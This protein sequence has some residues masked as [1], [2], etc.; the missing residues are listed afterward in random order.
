MELSKNQMLDLYKNMQRIRK[1]EEQACESFETGDVQGFLHVSIGEEAV[2]TGVCANLKKTDYITSTHRGHGHVLSKGADPK[3]MMAELCGRVDGY[4]HGKGGSM[5]IAN[6]DLGILGANGI[7]GAGQTLS[8]GAALA[9][10]I[11]KTDE[12]TVCFFGDGASNEGTFHEALNAA[13]LWGLPIVFVCTNNLYG[14]ST[15][16]DRSMNI[17]DISDRAV[18][19]GIPGVTA[20][21]NDVIEVYKVAQEAINRARN[22]GGPTLLEF[23]SYKWRGHFEGDPGT[24]RPQ[25]EVDEWKAKDPIKRMKMYLLENRIASDEELQKIEKAFE[26]EMQEAIDFAMD[27]DF[28]EE[29]SVLRD[30]YTDIIEEGR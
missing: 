3:I 26:L 2:P 21:G 13:S 22:G 8:V 15:R 7:V 23:K 17:K 27:S 24:Y 30:I 20:D 29:E 1:F 4:N 12:V 6:I 9:S 14:I 18:A 5:H 16:Q 11:R 28:P 10:K 25:E 19:Y